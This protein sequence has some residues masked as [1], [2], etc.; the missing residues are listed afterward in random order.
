[1]VLI[2]GRLHTRSSD[3]LCSSVH[4][5]SDIC[6]HASSVG[7]LGCWGVGVITGLSRCRSIRELIYHR[8]LVCINDHNHHIDS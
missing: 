2:R 6:R 7:V 5:V 8:G 4:S 1:M 3:T